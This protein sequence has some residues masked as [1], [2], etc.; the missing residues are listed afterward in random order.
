MRRKEHDAMRALMR[1]AL[2]AA[3]MCILSPLA[4]PVGP[5]PVTLGAFIVLLASMVL[6]PGQAMHAVLA[7]LLLGLVGL[8]VFSGGVGGPSVLL[9]PTGGYIWSYLPMALIASSLRGREG[10]VW[11]G[12]AAALLLC[13]VFGTLQFMLVMDVGAGEVLTLCVWPFVPFDAAKLCCA[14]LLGGRIRRRL[15]SAGLIE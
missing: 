11:V 8:P 4:I 2:F 13:Y 6:G 1:S 7:Y 14:V 5:V 10:L 15:Q 3:L 12:G 9:G